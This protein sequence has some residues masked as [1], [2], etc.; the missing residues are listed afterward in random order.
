M[1]LRRKHSK[2]APHSC[3]T[4]SLTFAVRK[5]FP[6]G[7]LLND[8]FVTGD[9]YNTEPASQE[10]TETNPASRAH[11]NARRAIRSFS[12]VSEPSP[13]HCR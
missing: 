9:W 13:V 1:A 2:P 5:S 11:L 7:G 3:K 6:F 10:C 12:P 4:F 8:V